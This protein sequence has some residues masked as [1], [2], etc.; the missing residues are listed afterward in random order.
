MYDPALGRFQSIDPLVEWDFKRSP[1]NYV[2]N[3]PILYIDPDGMRR[4]K[5]EREKAREER[6][7]KREQKKADKRGD[8]WIKEVA[9]T[10]KKP[11]SKKGKRGR[12]SSRPG[13]E[14]RGL[15]NSSESLATPT[16]GKTWMVIDFVELMR[17]FG[18]LE[19][20]PNLKPDPIPDAEESIGNAIKESILTNDK[21]IIEE[22]TGNS[23]KPDELIKI[24]PV[25]SRKFNSDSLV[26]YI[27][28]SNDTTEYFNVI[29]NKWHRKIAPGDTSGY[30][31][32]W[33][34]N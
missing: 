33:K 25:A 1:Y 26:P 30:I 14:I 7:L 20:I 17:I 13:I 24:K 2:G 6:R 23:P 9:C 34:L 22:T 11:S 28:T 27:N 5:E 10:A 31:R 18:L 21:K 16:T 19:L 32:N 12:I 29:D 15:G 4:T 3:N 8:K